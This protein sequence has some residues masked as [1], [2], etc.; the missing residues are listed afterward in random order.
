[1]SHLFVLGQ[2]CTEPDNSPFLSECLFPC[3]ASFSWVVISCALG[4]G[5]GQ[6]STANKQCYVKVPLF[7]PL[8]CYP[9]EPCFLVCEQAAEMNLLPLQKMLYKTRN[10]FGGSLVWYPNWC[11]R[12][13]NALCRS[14]I[15]L[16]EFFLLK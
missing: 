4:E 2:K 1:M 13:Q 12:T 16:Q 15:T 14:Q 7:P 9:W 10:G 11:L 3:A 6:F 8:L 5:L